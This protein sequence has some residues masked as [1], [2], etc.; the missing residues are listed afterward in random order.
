VYEIVTH[1][2]ILDVAESL[3]GPN[4]L[5]WNTNWFSKMPGEKSYVGWH[6]DGTYWNLNP[7][8]VVRLELGVTLPVQLP[9]DALERFFCPVCE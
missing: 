3:L 7:P 2:R 5:A 1:P 4:L 6:Q 9:P 8:T